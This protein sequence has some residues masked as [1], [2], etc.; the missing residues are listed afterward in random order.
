[1]KVN[2][3]KIDGTISS[4][5]MNISLDETISDYA[6]SVVSRVSKQNLKQ[7]TKKAKTRSEVNGRAKKPHKQKG[8]GNAR[9]GSRKGP[10][11][12]GGGV[13]HGPKPDHHKL[14]L[15]K[16][17]SNLVLKKFL[18]KYISE[19]KLSLIELNSNTKEL[20]DKLQAKSLIVYSKE[21]KLNTLQIRNISGVKLLDINSFSSVALLSAK[22]IYIDT[23][24]KSKLEGLMK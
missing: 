17:F 10:H 13:A 3:L 18:S 23:L 19:N 22:N 12:R 1:M 4:V 15:N 11:M 5:E 24:A 7:G 8:T 6:I 14:S 16:K 21:N 9:Q 20:K 2:L